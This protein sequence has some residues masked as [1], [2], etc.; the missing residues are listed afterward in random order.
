MKSGSNMDMV[1]M[2]LTH[3]ELGVGGYLAGMLTIGVIVFMYEKFIGKR[4]SSGVRCDDC[5]RQLD[6]I[7]GG[8]VGPGVPPSVVARFRL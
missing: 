3:I 5:Q 6:D 4:S 7:I 1:G 2:T 8:T